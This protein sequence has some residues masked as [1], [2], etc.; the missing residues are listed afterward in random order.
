MS[1]TKKKFVYNIYIL[2]TVYL[3]LIFGRLKGNKMHIFETLKTETIVINH[4]FLETTIKK[5]I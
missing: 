2:N 5:E 1:Q 3:K 4:I